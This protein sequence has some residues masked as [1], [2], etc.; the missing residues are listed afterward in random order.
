MDKTKSA[1]TL[2]LR[3]V[4]AGNKTKVNELIPLVY[5]ELYRLAERQ[6]YS[7]RAGHTLNPTALTHEAYLKLINQQQVDVNDRNHFYAVAAQAMR[8][9]LIDYARSKHSKK[10]GVEKIALTFVKENAVQEIP[11]EELLALDESLQRLSQHNERQ[12]KVIEYWFFGGLKHHEIAETLG[13]SLPS[14][15]RDWRL[16]RAWLS[17]EMK[18]ST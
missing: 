15:R 1:I 7:E 3:D 16:A 11:S 13:V 8:R 6:L 5:D 14:V 9:I 2:L 10:R 12:G 17:R 18:I 4:A